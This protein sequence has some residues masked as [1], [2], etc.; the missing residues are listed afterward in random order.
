M[1]EITLPVFQGPLDLLLHLIE[2]DD[3]DITAVS[4][5]AVTD[6]YL[7]AIRTN[8]GCEPGAWAGFGGVGGKR[9]SLKSRARLP[10]PP[11]EEGG[12]FDDDDVGRELVELLQEYKRFAQV[13]SL[14]EERQ[15]TGLRIYTRLA[16]P[17]PVPEGAGLQNVTVERLRAI[18]I[19]VLSQKPASPRA[20]VVIQRDTVMTLSDRVM[21]FR[22]RLRRRGKFSFRR[23]IME[24]RTR[25]EVI[26]SFLAILELLKAGIADARQSDQWGD[27]EVV[28]AES[29]VLA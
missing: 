28:A 14:L 6:Q 13:A 12:D 9:I 4:L 8:E 18:M 3:L 27:I 2:R 7:T 1:A 23:A 11:R 25:V 20:P 16:P 21:D 17:P 24:C 29:S 5:V 26:V 19:E 10:R 22:E 15:E